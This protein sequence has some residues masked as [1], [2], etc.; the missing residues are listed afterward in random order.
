MEIFYECTNCGGNGIK[1]IEKPQLIVGEKCAVC[2]C[3]TL[4]LSN[5]TTEYILV[6][7]KRDWCPEWLFW[8]FE[9][10]IK[11]PPFRQIFTI[12]VV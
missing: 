2:G 3:E 9:G 10:F 12:K 5:D 4:M 8:L 1:N 6:R 11:Y 7:K